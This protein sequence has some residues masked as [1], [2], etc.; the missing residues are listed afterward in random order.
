MLVLQWPQIFF[1]C[2]Y[3]LLLYRTAAVHNRQIKVSFP[4]V[5]IRFVLLCLLLGW[6]GFF[7]S[8]AQAQTIPAQAQRY[9]LEL[10]RAAHSQW[11]LDA[12]IA[13]LAAQVHQESVWNPQAVSRVGARGLAQ[14]MPATAQWWCQLHRIAPEQCQPHNPTWALRAL[15]GY[16]KYL[17][18]RTPLRFGGFDRQW[19]MLRSYNGGL[20]HW[21]AEAK[22][23]G[24]ARPTRVQ[25]DDACGQARRHRSHCSE[26]L[27]YP[28]QILQVLQPRY[29]SW[30]ALL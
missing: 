24:F 27:G 23:T 22:S 21:Q 26:N 8:T 13:A 10:V 6:G 25:V 7:S 14:F 18:D 4:T 16:D 17:F 19:V 29:Q 12:P 20:G 15:V 2:W 30:G 28:V 11:G 9:R 5:L 3:A 1:L